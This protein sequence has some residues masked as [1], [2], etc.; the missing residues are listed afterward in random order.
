[1]GLVTCLLTK[2]DKFEYSKPSHELEDEQPNENNKITL[3]NPQ[4]ENDYY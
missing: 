1:M 3:G 4:M 2:E